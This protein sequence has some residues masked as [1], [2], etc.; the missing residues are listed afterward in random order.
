LDEV[1]VRLD[2]AEKARDKAE[3]SKKK[4]EEEVR[5]AK[6]TAD[7]LNKNKALLQARVEK[8]E[9]DLKKLKTKLDEE[10]V[11]RKELEDGQARLV[12]QAK[13]ANEKANDFEA[14]AKRA[15][16]SL[17]DEKKAHEALKKKVAILMNN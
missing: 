8:A 15:G 11:L 9:G 2:T 6:K 12:K 10:E 3:K 14:E 17:N 16:D 1:K 13:D 4:Q 5:V 7:E